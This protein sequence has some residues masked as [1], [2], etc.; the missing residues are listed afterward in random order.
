M[1]PSTGALVDGG[2]VGS[3]NAVKVGGAG[4]GAGASTGAGAGAVGGDGPSTTM[5]EDLALVRFSR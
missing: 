2:G 1:A 3:N 5:D 4:F